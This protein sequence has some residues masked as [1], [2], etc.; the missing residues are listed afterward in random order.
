MSGQ[1]SSEFPSGGP[2]PTMAGNVL[3]PN[4]HA[5]GMKGGKGVG[6]TSE[7]TIKDEAREHIGGGSSGYVQGST[8][9]GQSSSGLDSQAGRSTGLDQNS[10]VASGV[11]SGAHGVGHSETGAGYGS[12]NTASSGLGNTSSTSRNDP[13]NPAD[14]T[15]GRTVD[16]NEAGGSTSYGNTNT[17]SS[18]GYDHTQTPSSTTGLGDDAVTRSSTSAADSTG[19]RSQLQQGTASGGHDLTDTSAKDSSTTSS[20]STGTKGAA[21]GAG[22]GSTDADYK[23][24]PPPNIPTAGGERIGTKHWGESK[25]IPDNPKPTAENSAGQPDGESI[26]PFSLMSTLLIET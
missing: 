4:V 7:H 10:G 26:R 18:S 8:G 1:Q 20:G 24:G 22:A 14:P 16:P 11:S 5:D 19:S 23:N 6:G 3:D 2:H 25:I 17:S 13:T 12:S 15:V 21:A 9:L